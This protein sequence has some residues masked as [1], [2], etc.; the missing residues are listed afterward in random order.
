MNT[1]KFWATSAALFFA[2]LGADHA[3]A[4]ENSEYRC[5]MNGL[6]SFVTVIPEEGRAEYDSANGRFSLRPFKPGV[7]A[8]DAQSASFEVNG[9]R[10]TLWFGDASF[11]CERVVAGGGRVAQPASQPQVHGQA[12]ALN[13]VG[14]SL[15]GK[16]RNGPGTNFRQTGSISEG[17]WLTILNNT[18]IT[19]DGYDWFEVALDNGQR[20]YQWGGI[21]CSNGPKI[22]GIYNSCQALGRSGASVS[23]QTAQG[24]SGYMAF[25]IGSNGRFGHGAG[26]TP[27]DAER[28]ALQYCGEPGCSIEDVTTAQCHA[29]AKTPGGVW[30]GSGENQQVANAAA[31]TFCAKAGAPECRIE[32]SYCR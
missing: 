21:M 28:F 29:L 17:T 3:A 6:Y 30:I 16:L 25:A 27:A 23:D 10:A 32:Y 31:M 26:K 13:V 14:Q 5:S 1:D 12:E 7:Y 18:H 24:G 20:G 11:P 8:N 2:L 15:G 4:S 22:Q 9:G 19:F